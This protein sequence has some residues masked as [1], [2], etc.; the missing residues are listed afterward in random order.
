MLLVLHP[1]TRWGVMPVDVFYGEVRER[2]ERT[3]VFGPAGDGTRPG[4]L[5]RCADG[6]VREFLGREGEVLVLAE[7]Y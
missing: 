6:T 7:P 3:M 4:D 5:V 1:L 2:P